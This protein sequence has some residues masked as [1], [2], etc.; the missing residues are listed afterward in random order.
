M[1]ERSCRTLVLKGGLVAAVFFVMI[2]VSAG[3]VSESDWPQWRGVGG[4]GVSS[5]T[6]LPVSWGPESENIRWKTIIAGDG[7]SSPVA[8]GDKVIVTTARES[9]GIAISGKV[10]AIACSVLAIAL[11][12]NI[13]VCFIVKNIRSESSGGRFDSLVVLTGSLVFISLALIAV[14]WPSCFDR[15]S[16]KFDFLIYHG[17]PDICRLVSMAEGAKAV[18]WLT[19]GAISLLGL[20]AA[21]GWLRARSTWR[22]AGVGMVFFGAVLLVALTPLNQWKMEFPWK[23]RS[24][25]T[26]PALALAIWYL[27]N[28]VLIRQSDKSA[29]QSAKG[30]FGRAGSALN[31]IEISLAKKGLRDFGS[32]GRLVPGV[33]ILMM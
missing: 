30:F 10:I 12:I 14:I 23:L 21:V 27:L 8:V 4:T 16:D 20:A 1:T 28:F 24:M 15:V 17:G 18:V 2:G 9:D 6:N 3:A 29:S 26:I 25:F 7:I 13:A 31:N 19:S 11:L 32:R 5:Q 22:L 33:L